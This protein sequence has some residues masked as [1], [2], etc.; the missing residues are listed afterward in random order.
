MSEGAGL[1]P[2]AVKSDTKVDAVM[3]ALAAFAF[4]MADEIEIMEF[5]VLFNQ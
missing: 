3:A 4:Y 2:S 1:K 5:P